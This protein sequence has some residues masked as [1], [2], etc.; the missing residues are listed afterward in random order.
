LREKPSR[1]SVRGFT[2]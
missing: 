2:T 1:I